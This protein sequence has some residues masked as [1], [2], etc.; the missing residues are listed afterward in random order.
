M[1]DDKDK[2]PFELPDGADDPGFDDI[3]GIS[4]E[5]GE[6][7]HVAPVVTIP[8]GDLPG[9]FPPQPNPSGTKPFDVDHSPLDR[10]IWNANHPPPD[11]G[12][13]YNPSDTLPDVEP[14]D[15]PEPADDPVFAVGDSGDAN[16]A[17][18]DAFG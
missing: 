14:C 16:P 6:D 7:G 17:G 10:A 12:P 9:E 18:W 1:P 13:L 11:A 4:V 8:A 5:W 3:Y 2:G 15:Y